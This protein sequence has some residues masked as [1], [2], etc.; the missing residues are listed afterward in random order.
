[1]VLLV[2]V[3][4]GIGEATDSYCILICLVTLFADAMELSHFAEG[5]QRISSCVFR[6]IY[7]HKYFGP[8]R[9]QHWKIKLK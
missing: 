7:F 8:H 4:G 1:M 3:A 2:L 9:F 5:D 6:R